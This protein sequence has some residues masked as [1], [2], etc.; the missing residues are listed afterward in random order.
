M[1]GPAVGTSYVPET[2]PAFDGR[3]SRG[4]QPSIQLAR[5]PRRRRPAMLAL[6]VALIGAGVLASAALYTTINKQ[7][8]VLVAT[9]EVPAGAVITAQDVGTA[10]VAAGPGV[11]VIPASQLQQ[12]IGQVAGTTLHPGML[13]TAAELATL[14]PP[15]PGL[16][17]VPLG[18]RPAMLPAS[19][20]APGDRVL[21]VAT[22][23]DQG[24][25]GSS[26]APVLTVPVPGVVESV[27]LAAN[28]DGFQVVDVLVAAGAGAEV[29]EQASTGQIALILTRRAP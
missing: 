22:P 23:G 10:S 3:K 6:A 28:P 20:L 21:I 2:D 14:R 16:V 5:L 9:A 27:A 11:A 1:T 12:V 24:Q 15:G 26:S 13:L 17:L 18:L 4:T 19:G 25:P 7:V 8:P 29:A